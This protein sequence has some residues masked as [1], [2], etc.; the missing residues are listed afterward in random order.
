MTFIKC[1][2][3]GLFPQKCDWDLINGLERIG[4]PF[5]GSSPTTKENAA[6]DGMLEAESSFHQ[7]ENLLVH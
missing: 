4:R 7:T 3:Q 5:F 6:T 2:S 1:L